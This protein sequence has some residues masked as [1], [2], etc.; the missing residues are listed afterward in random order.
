M[1][2]RFTLID[3]GC[4]RWQYRTSAREDTD[5]TL[6]ASA[7][8]TARG[9]DKNLRI[10]KTIHELLANRYLNFLAAIYFHRR[11][12]GCNEFRSRGENQKNEYKDDCGE[13]A[14]A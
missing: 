10:G 12:P 2:G 4:F 6:A 8:T 7:P 11:Q 5:A 13:Q 14:N 9:G 1:I 3:Q